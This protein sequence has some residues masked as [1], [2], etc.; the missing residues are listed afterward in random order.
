MKRTI[1]MGISL[2]FLI[3]IA[4]Q[5]SARKIHCV[6]DWVNYSVRC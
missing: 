3:G 6:R 1:V 2:L 4:S 5:A